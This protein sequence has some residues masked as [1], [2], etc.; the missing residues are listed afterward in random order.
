MTGSEIWTV[1]TT[2][3]DVSWAWSWHWRAAQRECGPHEG[4]Q[5]PDRDPAPDL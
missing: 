3:H 5:H 2:G 1:A 4:N